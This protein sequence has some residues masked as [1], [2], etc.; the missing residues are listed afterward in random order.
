[1]LDLSQLDNDAVASKGTD[2]AGLQ[3]ISVDLLQRGQYQ[4]RE[5]FDESELKELADSI[6]SQG[7]I[8]PLTIRPIGEGRYEII[9]GERRWRAA[10]LAKLKTV[11]VVIRE[12]NDETAL[13]MAI[14]E[15][16]QRKDLL[17]M[18]E[19]KALNRLKTEFSLSN[20][21]VAECVGKA[22]NDVNKL[23]SLLKL[24]EPL[25]ELYDNGFRAVEQLVELQRAFKENSE[26]TLAFLSDRTECT[27]KEVRDLRASFK[28]PTNSSTSVPDSK[29]ESQESTSDVAQN[30][31]T[32]FSGSSDQE[33][34]ELPPGPTTG[35][36]SF[37][38]KE[39]VGDPKILK[40][41]LLLV[42]VEN[43]AAVVLL[44]KKPDSPGLIYVKWEDGGGE[45][46]I[47]ATDCTISQLTEE[48]H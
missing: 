20:K 6:R 43:R 24:P 33:V 46:L 32:S 11:P 41:P 12:I 25:A 34:Q 47:S 7:V 5:V 23:L 27:L 3:E 22:A 21:Q 14:I 16:I 37:T 35:A 9:A 15:N 40:K 10:Q 8:Q 13:A 42:E 4:P 44:N 39:T 28:E 38:K 17:P 29:S 1:M 2:G 45:E 26:A 30:S 36:S 18:E 19:A 48:A 31:S